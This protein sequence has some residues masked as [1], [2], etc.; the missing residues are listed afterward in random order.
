MLLSYASIS[1][2]YCIQNKNST[3]SL[4]AWVCCSAEAKLSHTV[5]AFCSLYFSLSTIKLW[6]TLPLNIHVCTLQSLPHFKQAAV[7]TVIY[8]YNS[9]SVYPV[10]FVCMFCSL[11]ITSLSNVG[12]TTNLLCKLHPK[13]NKRNLLQISIVMLRNHKSACVCPMFEPVF[14]NLRGLTEV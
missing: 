9:N 6:N 14:P 1:K 5:T 10:F 4:L 11:C 12:Y 2:S 3:Q 8:L 7:L 13:W